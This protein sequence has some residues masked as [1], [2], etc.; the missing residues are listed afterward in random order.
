MSDF[1]QASLVAAA[2]VDPW[3]LR[4]QFTA[5][6]PEEIYAMARGF[7]QAAAQQGDAVTLATKGLETAGDGY[8]VN[9][10]TP[11]D[12][13]AQVAEASKQLGNNGE[14]LGKIAKLLSET[15]SDLSQRTAKANTQITSL[16]GDVNA[17]I[18]EWNQ[19]VRQVHN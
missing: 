14:K 15:A 4:D 13:N 9:N 5:G 16:T 6:D 3:T 8:K 11:I 7:N 10:A 17:I 18:G 19:F 2:G 1:S 12:V